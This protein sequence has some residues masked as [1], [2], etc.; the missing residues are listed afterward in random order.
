MTNATWYE[1][2]RAGIV[3]AGLLVATILVV[4]NAGD[5]QE[6]LKK[7]INGATRQSVIGRMRGE[8]FRFLIQLV[9]VVDAAHSL[10]T[11]NRAGAFLNAVHLP[12]RYIVDLINA[13]MGA[14][15]AGAVSAILLVWSIVALR[16]RGR[17][18]IAMAREL[19]DMEK[20]VVAH[21]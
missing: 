4:V 12:T 14:V 9:C 3:L 2:V 21:G 8:S 1:L 6:V 5:L 7:N 10:D 16:D 18:L 20:G 15:S 13:P 11:P 19:A 17:V